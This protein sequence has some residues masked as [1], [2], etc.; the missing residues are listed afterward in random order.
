[1]VEFMGI[2]MP[3]R[4]AHI[5]RN[6]IVL[7]Q[8][9]RALFS[10]DA[11][12]GGWTNVVLGVKPYKQFPEKQ[13]KNYFYQREHERHGLEQEAEKQKGLG[14]EF[15]ANQ[16]AGRA[17]TLQGRAMTAKAKTLGMNPLAFTPKP[18]TRPQL[19][20]TTAQQFKARV[21]GQLAKMYGRK[22]A[23]R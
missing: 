7:A 16:L 1:M 12:L 11:G 2:P 6:A 15:I 8:V 23:M 5:A 3:A 19:A 22:V 18:S 13:L 21:K 14:N 9:D 10:E 17:E 20:P 4:L